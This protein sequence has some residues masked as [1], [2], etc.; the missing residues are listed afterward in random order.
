[1]STN[2]NQ[3]RVMP[4]VIIVILQWFMWLILPA[5]AG[6]E[7]M[8]AAV[9]GGFLGGVAVAIWW[10]FWS[11]APVIDRVGAVLLSI[12]SLLIA[13]RFVDISI[14]TA[15]MGLLL[16]MYS[17]PV[18]SL[19]LV[20][21]AVI[22]KRMPDGQRRAVIIAAI[23]IASGL[24]L[25]LKTEGVTGDF[26][27]E[28]ALRWAKTAEQKFLEA[29]RENMEVAVKTKDTGE[30][31][32]FR[33]KDR[34]GIARGVK[35]SSDWKVSPPVLLWQRPVGPGC[36]SFAVSAGLVYTQE[37]RGKEEAVTCYD[38]ANGKPVWIHTDNARFWDSH[39]G[40]GPRGTPTLYKGRVYTFG[41]TGILN[42]LDAAKGTLIWT[43]D[44]AKDANVKAL[45]WGFS[46]S[47][48]IYGDMV[49]IAAAGKMAAYELATGKP[50]WFGP[51]GGRSYS[52]PHLITID[53]IAQILLLNEP[54][55]ISF[56]PADGKVLW[57]YPWKGED[58]VIQPALTGDGG[59]L[60]SATMQ[61][62]KR[63][64][65]STD[66][67]KNWNIKESWA[68]NSAKPNFNDY[69]VHKGFAYGYNGL[70]LVCVDLKDGS[71]KWK[72][73]HYGGQ[74]IL[75]AD[76]DLLLIAAEKG[77]LALVLAVPDKFT[78]LARF[79]AI[80]GRTWNHPALAGNIL[81]VR[82]SLEM[83]AFRLPGKK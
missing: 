73:G 69:A 58:R 19:A 18:M 55:C 20:V 21:S 5:L 51:E 36:S 52:S 57:T 78:E 81:L 44:V 68:S 31:P 32:G 33:G 54:G 79:P 65:V 1:M 26:K 75:I 67:N 46:S 28:F 76:Q 48:L 42:V 23:I 37:Q 25:F 41:G 53:G 14:A 66:K 45:T 16:I 40:T 59:F 60:L 62:M 6:E 2:E 72:G 74:L 83:A 34:D 77:N 39:V 7:T 22:T 63:L 82:N 80:K 9:A 15:N 49:Y 10:L 38:L 50:K 71:L 70:S 56:N 47:P 4:G 8:M 12:V 13:S 17:V 3:L 27:H 30:W 11:K 43:R 35:I 61:K 64:D 29:G 24:W